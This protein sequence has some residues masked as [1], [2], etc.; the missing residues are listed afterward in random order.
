MGNGE[1]EK[2]KRLKMLD[3]GHGSGPRLTLATHISKLLILIKT[4]RTHSVG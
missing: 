1:E 3:G 2:A 4:S